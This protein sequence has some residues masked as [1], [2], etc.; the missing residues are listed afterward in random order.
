VQTVFERGTHQSVF[1]AGIVFEAVDSSQA[2]LMPH[3]LAYR[4]TSPDA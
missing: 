2:H 1:C 3:A 4:L